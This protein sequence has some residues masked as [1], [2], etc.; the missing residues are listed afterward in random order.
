[1]QMDQRVRRGQTTRDKIIETSLKLFA[2]LGYA[3]V[4]IESVLRECG[5]SRGALYHHFAS[6]DAIFE[7]VLEAAE[8]RVVKAASEAAAKE[9]NPLDALRAGCAAW[10]ELASSDAVVRQIVLTDAPSV[11]GW[12]RWRQIDNRYGL[13]LLKAGFAALARAGRLPPDRVDLS[14]HALLAVLTEMALLLA[15]SMNEQDVAAGKE[16]VEQVLSRFA[17]VEPHGSWVHA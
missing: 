8:L 15:R 1:M 13:G 17:G 16:T 7:A 3:T 6:K 9:D 10:L 12:E 2:E 11:V 5:I 4:S 14:A